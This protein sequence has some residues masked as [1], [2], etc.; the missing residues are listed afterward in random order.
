M[1]IFFCKDKDDL[2]AKYQSGELKL[3]DDEYFGADGLPYCQKCNGKRWAIGADYASWCS[4]KCMQEAYARQ[5]AEEERQKKQ[6][7]FE[8]RVVLSTLMGKHR[9]L[10]FDQLTIT[11]HNSKAISVCRKYVAQAKEMLSRNIGLYFYGDNSTGK[12]YLTATLCN[13]LMRIGYQCYFTNLATLLD[14][15]LRNEQ[16][17]LDLFATVPF[18]FIDD[19]GK[20]FI[21]RE[22][23]AN[24]AKWAEKKLFELLNIRA[25]CNLPTLFSSNYTIAELGEKLRLDKG[26]L[27]RINVMATIMLHLEGDNFREAELQD[28]EQQ[29]KKLLGV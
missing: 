1:S 28:K 2:V 20:E 16:P 22:N 25:N 26:I 19:L 23:N 10:K 21:D 3:R 11:Q 17:I 27:E 6:Q 13:E 4:C 7:E 5:R 24:S 9:F 8:Q 29:A 18:V 14:D 12:T 15:I